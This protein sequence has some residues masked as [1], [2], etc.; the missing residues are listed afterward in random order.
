MSSELAAV[1]VPNVA[2][3]CPPNPTKQ[4]AKN[5]IDNM[6]TLKHALE[7][8]KKYGEYAKKYIALEARTYI[9]IANAYDAQSLELSGSAKKI[10]EFLRGMDHDKQQQ[11]VKR[12]VDSGIRLITIVNN[13]LRKREEEDDIA[14]A[15]EE[16]L[17]AKRD[18][19]LSGRINLKERHLI[20]SSWNDFATNAILDEAKDYM[21]KAGAVGI[22]NYVYVDPKRCS[23]E[24]LQ[25]AIS[26]RL[27][28]VLDDL[29]ALHDIC[30]RTTEW[31]L[32]F[33]AYIGKRRRGLQVQF[34]NAIK[35]FIN[36][37]GGEPCESR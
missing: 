37:A 6:R 1:E 10:A 3:L 26:I 29:F 28:S 18:F 20:S 22:G 17:K 12:C 16:V 13:E 15:K 11:Y 25:Q 8:A 35:A 5:A 2:S 7:A 4:Q 27:K 24:E 34:I 14:W 32:A 30:R 9:D 36:M 19:K 23:D 33:D 31:H 21:L